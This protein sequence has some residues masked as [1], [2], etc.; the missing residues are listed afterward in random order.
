M[1]NKSRKNEVK[2]FVV[3]DGIRFYPTNQ[4]YWVGSVAPKKIRRMHIYVWEKAN[5]PVPSGCLIHHIDGNKSNN[6]L[7]NLQLVTRK[8]HGEL[9]APENREMFRK[10]MAECAQPAATAWHKSDAGREWHKDQY[11]KTLRDKWDD[12]ITKSCEVCGKPFQC[13]SLVAYKSRFCSNNCRAQFRRDSGVDNITVSCLIC[14]KQYETNKYARQKFCSPECR[15]EH[16]LRT[17][18]ERK[19][20][21]IV[22][23]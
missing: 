1:A 2:D 3:L 18:R 19:I 11:K 16:R 12:T 23:D 22:P 10:I 7:E 8:K 21:D 4:G 15:K 9:H 6:A 5:G 13:S 20:K 17:N 14:G